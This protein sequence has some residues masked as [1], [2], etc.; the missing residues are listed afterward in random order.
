MVDVPELTRTERV[1]AI[2]KK[3]GR[4]RDFLSRSGFDAV[5]LGRKDNFSWL[6]HGGSGEVV[7]PTPDG[8]AVVIVS[9]DNLQVVANP[10]DGP[11]ILA[12][13]LEGVD[14]EYVPVRWYETT[15]DEKV[16]DLTSG[17]RIISDGACGG[18]RVDRSAIWQLHYPLTELEIARLRWLGRATEEILLS[19]SVGT[20][21]GMTE[22]Q[23]AARMRGE[24]G[25]LGIDCDV[26]LVGSDER[27]TDFRHPVPSPKAVKRY[28]LMHAAAR[29]WGLH[30]NVT[31]LLHFGPVPEE[32]R[33]RHAT[34]GRVHSVALSMCHEGTRFADILAAQKETYREMGFADEWR[35]HFQGGL[36]GY[37]LGNPEL[38]LDNEA[39]VSDNQA[40]DWFITVT[41]AKVEELSLT[42]GGV[43]EIPSVNGLWPVETVVCRDD[44]L[45]VPEIL[46]R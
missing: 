42:C 19:V 3:I 25:E 43:H 39:T 18:E 46:E 28:V 30:A 33:L 15:I 2:T 20:R 27:V 12:E 7:I 41:G 16:G 26:L 24:Y 13:E 45:P 14:V 23:I 37:T 29:K 38:A 5:A 1:T 21:P 17:R 4:L 22:L 34:A 35:N 44:A 11:R 6:T 9:P 36:T 40:F 32:T 10:T 31:R 8:V